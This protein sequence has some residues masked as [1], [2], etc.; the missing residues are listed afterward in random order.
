MRQV[1]YSYDDLLEIA[2]KNKAEIDFSKEWAQVR[3]TKQKEPT[4]FFELV[5]IP[6]LSTFRA[7]YMYQEL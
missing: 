5:K 6:A 1:N 3:I 4:R 2:S 7:I